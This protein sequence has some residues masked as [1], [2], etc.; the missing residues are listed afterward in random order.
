MR[1]L[2]F[3]LTFVGMTLLLGCGKTEV[4]P[5]PVGEMTE[6]KDPLYNFT[7]SYPKDWKQLGTSGKALFTKSQEIADKF[8]DP[9]SPGIEGAQMVVEVIS[10]EGNTLSALASQSKAALEDIGVSVDP[11]AQVA[12][13]DTQGIKLRYSYQATSSSKIFGYEIFVAGGD[14]DTAAYKITVQGFGDQ[15]NAHTALFDAMVASFKVPVIVEKEPDEWQASQ[16]MSKLDSPFLTLSY[17][18]N[19]EFVQ[20]KKDD[21]DYVMGMRADRQDVS[22]HVDVFGAVGLT[23]DKVWEQ[24]KDNYNRSRG[25]GETTI[26]GLKTLWVDYSPMR[27]VNSRA[28]FVVKNDKV[29]RTTL[30]WFAPQRNVYFP[31]LEAMVKSIKLK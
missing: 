26:D 5:V 11:E 17:P 12:I 10:Y 31:V 30:N 25:S 22:I 8:L 23:V 14:L 18:D 20:V 15:F 13:G 2:F 28:Y 24:N 19:M 7:I 4:P 9:Q 6:Y 16:N 21:K 27:N 3:L 29:I 1:H